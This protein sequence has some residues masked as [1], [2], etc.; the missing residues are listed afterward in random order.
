[1]I[2]SSDTFKKRK[3]RY[4]MSVMLIFSLL[5]ASAP[6]F[7]LMDADPF[8][9]ADLSGAIRTVRTLVQTAANP[10]EFSHN[11]RKTVTSLNMA[12]GITTRLTSEKS[13]PVT[14]SL[15]PH[16]VSSSNDS[17]FFPNVCQLVL[18]SVFP[19]KSVVSTPPLRPPISPWFL[20]RS[21]ITRA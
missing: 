12:T 16:L 21:K 13:I 15:D 5:F 7:S 14:Q 3:L 9:T 17:L 18:N 10:E 19:I 1:M 8:G 6:L 4:T 2:A 11:F 20:V